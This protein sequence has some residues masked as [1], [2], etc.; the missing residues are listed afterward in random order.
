MAE[1]QDYRRITIVGAGPAGLTA[2]LAAQK[3]GFEVRVFEQAHDF[4]QVGGG[5]LIHS[6]GQQVLN[7]L[8]LLEGFEPQMVLVK[9]GFIEGLNGRILTEI[10][11]S[12]IDVPFNRVAVI[13]RYQLQEYLL[14]AAIESGIEVNFNYHLTNINLLE[15]QAFLHFE[16]GAEIAA[17]IVI[18]ADGVNSKTRD[19]AGFDFQKIAIGEG[20]VR[21][22]SQIHLSNQA[23]REIW[24]DDGRRFGIAP[25]TG[26]ETYFYARV[27]LGEWHSI[28]EKRLEE[29]IESWHGFKD[30]IEILRNVSDW[31]KINYSELFEIRAEDWAK[32]PIFLVGDAA[33]AMTPNVGQGANSAMVDALVLTKM[34]AKAVKDGKSLEEVGRE[35]TALRHP[36]V[37]KIQN[38]ARQ[39]GALAAKT[40]APAHFFREVVFTVSRNVDS[41]R[42]KNLLVSAGYNPPEIE[43]LKPLDNAD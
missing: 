28:R 5:V 42:R 31:Q 17:E 36:F 38:I 35:Y 33:H 2:A 34:L 25:L 30:A 27:P 39:S 41:L 14:K 32:P 9:K 1:K 18:A 26:D 29:W 7:A 22:A 8:G 43:Y 15:K 16:N 4:K 6:N 20:W 23:F 37:T 21:G 10:D 3:L 13:W 11:F 24:G 12:E 19:R 40:S